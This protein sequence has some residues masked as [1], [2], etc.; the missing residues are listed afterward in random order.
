MNYQTIIYEKKDNYV[1]ITL[2]RP[3]KLNALNK[4]MF[5]DLDDAF[6]KIELDREVHG[7][8]L[9]GTGEKAFAAGADIKELNESDDRSGKLFSE[10]GSKVMK[11]LACLKIPTIA[12]IN[13][14]A[15]GG[16]CEL[17]LACQMRFASENAKMGQ[18]EVNLGIIPGY[19]GTQRLTRIVGKAKAME[20][21]LSANML[22]AEQAEKIGLVNSVYKPEELL[23]KTKEFMKLIL[24]KGPLA[25]FA[26]VECIN[27]AEELS[28]LEGLEFESRKFG[29]VCGTEDFKEGTNAF[30]EKRKAEFK[31]K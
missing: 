3:D 19:G 6:Q 10:Y 22:N 9:T 27:A 15:L 1:V 14:F 29:E 24:S 31:G 16:G 7:L 13:G 8:I 21:I 2:N 25:V 30:L 26:A 20:L 12:A 17:T 23:Q 28:P 4:Q 5:D 11:R 18:P